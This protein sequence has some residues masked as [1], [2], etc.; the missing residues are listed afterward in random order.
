[1]MIRAGNFLFRTRNMLFPLLYLVLFSG[2]PLASGHERLGLVIGCAIILTGQAIRVL[3]VGLDYIVRGGRNKRVYADGLVQNGLFAHCRNPLYLGNLLM[4]IGMGIASDNLYYLLVAMPLLFIAYACI[5]AAEE[6][7]LSGRFGEQYRRYMTTTPRLFPELKGLMNT[8]RDYPFNW[9]RVLVKEYST[10]CI[11]LL[12]MIAL[13]YQALQP[14]MPWQL[15]LSLALM[16]GLL[17]VGIRELK[18]R[19]IL[20]ARAV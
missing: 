5:I 6:H 10:L 18:K 11:S 1:M 12:V 7:Y 8:L 17:C 3:T 13:S 2:G 9:Q 20:R 14:A 16:V 19:G 4:I 15:A